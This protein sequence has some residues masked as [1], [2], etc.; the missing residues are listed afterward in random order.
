M[1]RAG[2]VIA[3]SLV[4]AAERK[5]I[6]RDRRV[7]EL[8]AFETLLVDAHRAANRGGR[9]DDDDGCASGVGVDVDQ[10]VE[11]H[12][13]A[14]LLARLADRRH[15]KRLAAVDV[16]AGEHPQSVARFD[17]PPD[18]HQPVAR[19]SDDRADGDLRID[20]EDEAAA[21]AD[22]PFRI[23]RIEETALERAAAS[24]AELI[25]VRVV[26]WVEDLCRR[27]ALR[28]AASIIPSIC[29]S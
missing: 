23:G 27:G 5:P 25:G 2:E 13:E 10:A 26:V 16:A 1:S 6:P 21:R 9:V 22:R 14:T 3:Q 19:A 24:R 11:A 15:R 17:R 20:V 12:V 4:R 18:E 8:G 28:R 29:R 7:V